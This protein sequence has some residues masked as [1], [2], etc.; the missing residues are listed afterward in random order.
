MNVFFTMIV[1]L[2]FILSFLYAKRKNVKI[3]DSFTSGVKNAFPLVLS[4]YPYLAAVSMLS[5]LFSE[6]GLQDGLG[7]LLSPALRF[8]GI[9]EEIFPLLFVKPLSG[10][11]ATA[12]LSDVLAKYGTDSYIARCACV[13][14]GSSET[15]F[16]I[17]AV[18]FASVKRKRLSLAAAIAVFS[19]LCS[20]V[21]ACFLCTVL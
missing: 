10:S 8:L 4:I 16:Y 21:L 14:Y 5:V 13:A 9:P 1:P 12:V 2:I 15:I 6:S 19:F 3:Y 7:T 20:S 11:G 17:S 18:Y